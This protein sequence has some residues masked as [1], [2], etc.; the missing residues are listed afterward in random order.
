MDIIVISVSWDET[1]CPAPTDPRSSALPDTLARQAVA[2]HRATTTELANGPADCSA[3]VS[4]AFVAAPVQGAV[5]L[6]SYRYRPCVS[7]LQARVLTRYLYVIFAS[8]CG[9]LGSHRIFTRRSCFFKASLRRGAYYMNRSLSLPFTDRALPS[10]IRPGG[11][12]HSRLAR[13]ARDSRSRPADSHGAVF[14]SAPLLRLVSHPGAA[15]PIAGSP[16]PHRRGPPRLPTAAVLRLSGEA[17]GYPAAPLP[18]YPGHACRARQAHF[19][20]VALSPDTPAPHPNPPLDA[21]RASPT[22]PRVPHE[23][24][25]LALPCR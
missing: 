23:T 24:A 12:S 16:S 8:R 4:V 21:R 15:K 20:P 11:V 9:N 7:T 13:G 2:P 18:P 17:G 3:A 14:P 5:P 1:R 6:N 25:A 22:P 19:L 10:A